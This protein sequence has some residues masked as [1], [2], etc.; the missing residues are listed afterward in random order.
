M[1]KLQEIDIL[2]VFI[3]F[4]FGKYYRAFLEK[5]NKNTFLAILEGFYF[6]KNFWLV[7]AN[8]GGASSDSILSGPSTF[9]F[10]ARALHFVNIEK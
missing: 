2:C 1:I 8:H 9:N 5:K 4:I 6:Q 3:F 7:G 10:K